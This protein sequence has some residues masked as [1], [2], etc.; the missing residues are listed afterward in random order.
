MKTQR[1]TTAAPKRHRF[2]IWLFGGAMCLLSYWLLGFIMGD[3][4]SLPGPNYS[5]LE[6]QRLDQTLVDR[7]DELSGQIETTKRDSTNLQTTQ[8]LLRESI[9]SSQRTL[10]QLMDVQ[11]LALEKG[12]ELSDEQQQSMTG[13]IQLFL[14]N[15][16]RDQQLNGEISA[17]NE[18]RQEFESLH[19]TVT[20][21]LDAARE[22]ISN[23]FR[24]LMEQHELKMGGFKLT[25]L[26]PA[27][28]VA[29]IVLFRLKL[30]ASPYLPL[31]CAVGIAIALKVGFVM[32]EHF[33]SRYFKYVLI[34]TALIIVT[35][36]L[37]SLLRAVAFPKRNWLLKQ[38]REAYESFLCPMCDFP[39]RRG[40]LRYLSWTRSSI[41]K[42]RP[43]ALATASDNS[44]SEPYTCPTCA[45]LLF[46]QCGKCESVR[47]SLL[48]ACEHCGATKEIEVA[49][50][51]ASA[52]TTTESK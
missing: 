45:T 21:Q 34:V 43:G 44:A 16:E 27:L 15:Q 8:K 13:N 48:P 14:A 12:V 39:I 29:M 11:K 19:R 10:T 38:Y 7:A 35:T 37:V 17:F 1:H 3:I 51:A 49:T 2:L 46:E 28:V 22:P 42:L 40:P 26:V 33:P 31:A 32:H 47:H 4:G 18:Q 5:E 20:E 25:V 41:R 52:E 50:K 36:I 6:E 9:G 30:R 24:K 23:E